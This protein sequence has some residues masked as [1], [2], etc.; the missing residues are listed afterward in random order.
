MTSIAICLLTSCALAVPLDPPSESATVLHHNSGALTLTLIVDEAEI[1]IVL[2][3]VSGSRWEGMYLVPPAGGSPGLMPGVIVE[4]TVN[5][6]GLYEYRSEIGWEN[7]IDIA[8]AAIPNPTL[9]SESPIAQSG[10]G[11][12]CGCTGG[13]SWYCDSQLCTAQSTCTGSAPPDKCK[14][15]QQ[16]P[17][18]SVTETDVWQQL[19]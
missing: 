3:P 7:P 18:P 16:N 13:S 4:R 15:T 17:T 10:G 8:Y 2:V 12:V 14:W 1:P 9:G 19:D 11:R 5:G 6:G